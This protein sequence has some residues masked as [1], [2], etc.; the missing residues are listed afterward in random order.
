MQVKLNLNDRVTVT[1]TEAG[2]QTLS[3]Y[4]D[5]LKLPPQYRLPGIGVD[6]RFSTEL[7]D[8]M[9]IFGVRIF[10][11]GPQLFKENIVEMGED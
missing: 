7:W 2:R 1:L 11:G 4:Y 3:G 6:G 5:A 9:Q 10:M 8:L